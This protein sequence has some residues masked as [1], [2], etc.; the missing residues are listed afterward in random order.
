MAKPAV[1]FLCIGV[2]FVH[3]VVRIA[4]ERIDRFDRFPFWFGEGEKREVEIAQTILREVRSNNMDGVGQF[5]M[6]KWKNVP[7][8]RRTPSGKNRIK[9]SEK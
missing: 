3:N 6:D 2:V 5:K 7:K 1:F 9:N 4:A 8:V